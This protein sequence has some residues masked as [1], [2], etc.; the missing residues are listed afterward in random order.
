MTDF[1]LFQEEFKVWQGK[2]GLMGYGVYFK[3]EEID[4]AFADISINHELMVATVRLNNK[5]PDEI[6]PFSDIK[7]D[8]KH[9]AIH[10]LIGR[11]EMNG[12]CREVSSGEIFEAS[13]ELANK[14]GNLI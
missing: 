10:L 14:L 11:L 7:R 13:E 12:R 5:L 8:A 9:E 1:E 6:K 4:G 2:F 3:H